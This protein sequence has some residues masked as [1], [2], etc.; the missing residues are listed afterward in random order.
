MPGQR[1]FKVRETFELTEM[2]LWGPLF[3]GFRVVLN[4]LSEGF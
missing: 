2:L 1:D 3:G 4:W